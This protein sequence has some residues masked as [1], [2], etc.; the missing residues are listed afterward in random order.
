MSLQSGLGK[1]ERRVIPKQRVNRQSRAAFGKEGSLGKED[2][3]MFY[4][5][6]RQTQKLGKILREMLFA[7]PLISIAHVPS[8]SIAVKWTAFSTGCLNFLKRAMMRQTM[9]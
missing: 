9:D 4:E 5:A 3:A 8:L 7:M 1:F 2:Q 6:D